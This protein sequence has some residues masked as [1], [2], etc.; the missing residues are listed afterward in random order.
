MY[1]IG[2]DLGGTNMAAGIVNE[3]G[4]L[5]YKKSIPTPKEN[6]NDMVK[7][8]GGLINSICEENNISSDDIKSVGI[9]IPGTIDSESGVIIYTNN[10]NCNNYPIVEKLKE[11][12]NQTYPDFH[13]KQSD[14]DA[15]IE[16]LFSTN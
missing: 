16:D 1:Y 13:T 5:L 15:V 14:D 12:A 9:G 6:A 10:L 8:M 2:I 3:K 4:E 7:N 11:E